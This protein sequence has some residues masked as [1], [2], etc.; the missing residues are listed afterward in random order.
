MSER[1]E[2]LY[3]EEISGLPDLT[4]E[5]IRELFERLIRGDSDAQAALSGGCLKRVVRAVQALKIRNAQIMDLIQEGNL[6]LLTFLQ[7]PER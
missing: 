3:L 4:D 2:A 5:E 6:A 7:E 1:S